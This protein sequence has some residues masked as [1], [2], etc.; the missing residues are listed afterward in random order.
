MHTCH[1][2]TNFQM[3]HPSSNGEDVADGIVSLRVNTIPKNSQTGSTYLEID[4]NRI[5][6]NGAR[7]NLRGSTASLGLL[8]T[9]SSQDLSMSDVEARSYQI[10]NNGSDEDHRQ[11]NYLLTS[12]RHLKF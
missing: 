12:L 10:L 9:H 3:L 1:I 4:E 8:S 7:G 11:V 5:D 2:F 6:K